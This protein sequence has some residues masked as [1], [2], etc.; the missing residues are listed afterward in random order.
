MCYILKNDELNSK[1]KAA[2][3]RQYFCQRLQT[4]DNT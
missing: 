3:T 2:A 1:L 4:Y